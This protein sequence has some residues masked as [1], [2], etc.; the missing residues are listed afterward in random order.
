V[1]PCVWK[2][3]R[4]FPVRFEGPKLKATGNDVAVEALEI[5]HEGLWQLSVLRLGA[6]AVGVD[7]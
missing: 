2:F 1:N 5:A 4:G 7:L 6:E 3:R